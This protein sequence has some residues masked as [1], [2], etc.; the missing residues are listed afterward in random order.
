MIPTTNTP[1]RAEILKM[2]R[3]LRPTP[4]QQ[5]AEQF[6][7][8]HLGAAKEPTEI[9]KTLPEASKTLPEPRRFEQKTPQ[10]KVRDGN[11][12]LCERAIL[13]RI[14]NEDSY[15]PQSLTDTEKNYVSAVCDEIAAWALVLQ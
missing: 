4:I 5:A 6:R 12:P 10:I 3:A 1:T 2:I 11:Q 13:L 7:S 14:K 9:A 8:R 15:L